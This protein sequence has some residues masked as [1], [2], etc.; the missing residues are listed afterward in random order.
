MTALTT[1]NPFRELEPF[2]DSWTIGFDRPFR[3]L[4][5]LQ[6]STKSTYPPY[7][8]R[9][10]EDENYE[11]ELAAAG[12]TREDIKVELKENVLTIT[13]EKTVE[14]SGYIHKGIASRDFKQTFALSDDVKVIS[15]SMTDGVLK[16]RLE[17]EIP[18][19]KKARIIEIE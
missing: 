4:E 5:E 15:A 18:E 3:I 11:I 9:S 14:E 13:G 7:N 17:R 19:H 16:V 2:M 8:I 1:Y 10:L 12:F 6:R